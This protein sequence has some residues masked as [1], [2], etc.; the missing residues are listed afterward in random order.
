MS[1]DTES[2]H[3]AGRDRNL[4]LTLAAA[5]RTAAYYGPDNAV[6]RRAYRGGGLGHGWG[7]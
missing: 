1:V 6:A 7:P 4:A 5:I 2:G 3:A